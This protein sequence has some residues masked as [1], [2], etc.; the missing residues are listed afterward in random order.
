MQLNDSIDDIC[1]TD[2]VNNSTEDIK[3]YN[4]HTCVNYDDNS[5]LTGYAITAKHIDIGNNIN[6]NKDK[7]K[8]EINDCDPSHINSDVHEI[9]HMIIDN[10]DPNSGLTG[11]VV[12]SKQYSNN[13]G[14]KMDTIINHD[15]G[16]LGR[17]DVTLS[18]CY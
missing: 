18:S 15:A 3:E 11:Y 1:R 16:M 5:D 17:T 13:D 8:C 14:R 9:N 2:N 10:D 6:D 12:A 7:Y 4:N